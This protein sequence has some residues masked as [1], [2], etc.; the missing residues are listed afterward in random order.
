MAT[1]KRIVDLD[2]YTNTNSKS[3]SYGKCFGRIHHEEPIDLRGM[4]EEIV[5]NGSPFTPDT[6]EG[7]AIRLRNCMVARLSEGTGVKID[8]LGTFRPTL[9]NEKGGADSVYDYNVNE[10]VIGVHVRFIPEGEKLDR[11]TSRA[12]KEQC[13]LRKTFEVTYKTITHG[14][15]QV[16]VPVYTPIITEDE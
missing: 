7:V 11:I 12:M 14:G 6:V 4:C 1:T 16:K 3:E 8:G 9:K 2:I 10:H 5:R 15:K 13:I